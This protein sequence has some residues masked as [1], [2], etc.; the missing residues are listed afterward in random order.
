M[1]LSSLSSFFAPFPILAFLNF[2]AAVGAHFLL[3]FYN[4][5]LDNDFLFP[6]G[7][8]VRRFRLN[9]FIFDGQLILGRK[10]EMDKMCRKFWKPFAVKSSAGEEEERDRLPISIICTCI[11]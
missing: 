6:N 4:A 9:S 1:F 5:R 2:H 7:R 10:E 8:S 11:G 3:V